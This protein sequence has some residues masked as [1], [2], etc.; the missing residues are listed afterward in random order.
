MDIPEIGDPRFREAVAAIDAGDV[1]ALERLLAAHPALLRDRLDYGEGY[2]RRPHLL[3][4]VAEN[5]IRNGRLPPNI[6]E[7]TRTILRAAERTGVKSVPA[8]RDYALGLVCSGRVPR[9]CGVQ[10]E[11]IDVLVDAG[12]RADGA[13]LPAL[14]HRELAAVERLLERGAA[15]TL[16][17]AAC[18]GRAGDV[19]RLGPLASAVERQ[20]ALTGAALHGLAGI[21]GQVIDLGVDLDAYSPEGFHAHATALHHAV[22]SGSLDAV[23]VLVEAGA[24]LG[25]RDRMY[26]G[27]PLDWAEYLGHPEIAA[28]LR[29]A[30]AGR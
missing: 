3:W 25:T 10:V 26:D 6:A 29:E 22:D 4:F 13:L 24:A 7:V 15:L 21:L 17:A 16:T 12:A 5:P 1:G 18:T 27:T 19:A 14:A 28:Y 11:L 2:F 9:E 30:A 23:R 20:T 8:Q